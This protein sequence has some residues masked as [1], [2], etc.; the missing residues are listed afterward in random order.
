MPLYYAEALNTW[1]RIDKVGKK[2][3]S[4]SIVIP[5]L[6]E[7]FSDFLQRLT[8]LSASRMKTNSEMRQ[9]TFESLA[10]END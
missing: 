10:F 5:A 1:D 3:E 4:F 6:K 7:A 8:S 9:I 2:I